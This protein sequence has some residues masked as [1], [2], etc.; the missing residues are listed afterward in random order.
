[1]AFRD[2]AHLKR[3][4]KSEWYKDHLE[5]YLRETGVSRQTA[6]KWDSEF[7]DF[8]GA[9]F[10][11]TKAARWRRID[12]TSTARSRRT[13]IELLKL[14]GQIDVLRDPETIEDEELPD[15]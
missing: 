1:M 12:P 9:S 10:Y 15:Y 11:G 7:N 6:M 14:E 4:Q 2:R 8:F 13:Y 5:R 3:V